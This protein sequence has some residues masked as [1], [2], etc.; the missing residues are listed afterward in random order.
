MTSKNG[1]PATL[2]VTVQNGF[3]RTLNQR[4]AGRQSGRRSWSVVEPGQGFWPAGCGRA[5]E[6]PHPPRRLQSHD[7][8]SRKFGLECITTVDSYRNALRPLI[9]GARNVRVNYAAPLEPAWASVAWSS[10]RGTA[11]VTAVMT[12]SSPRNRPSEPSVRSA[13]PLTRQ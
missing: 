2:C 6:T 9:Q 12:R 11:P 10:A 7:S 5:V 8:R 4:I 13:I 3:Y 1:L